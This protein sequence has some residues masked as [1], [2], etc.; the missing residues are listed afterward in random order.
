VRFSDV[1]SL[2]GAL[3][4]GALLITGSTSA[5]AAGNALQFDG[6]NDY[7]TFGADTVNLGLTKFTVELWFY[8]TGTGVTTST[9]T[10]GVTAVPLFT[11]GR[12]EADGNNR[13][14]NY[15]LGIRGTDNV[16]CADYEEGT[17][18]TSPGLNHPVAGVTAIRNNTWYHA[19]ATFDGTT[20]RLYLN[21]VLETELVVGASRL[22]QDQ[23]IQHAGL[24][25]AMTSTGVAAGYFLGVLDEA[26]IWG[27]ALTQ[28]E[29]VSNMGLELASGTGLNGRWGLNDGTGTTADNSIAASPDGTLTN[30]PVWVDGCPFAA[31]N[32]LKLGASNAYATFGNP[33]A[34]G[35]AQFT[36]ETWF[37][38][39]G[40]GTAVSTGTGGITALPLVTHG[41]A[42]AEGGNLDMNWFLGIRSSD[43][44]ICADFEEATTGATPGLNHPIAG[45]TPIATGQW[46][47]AAAT[48]DGTSWRLYLNGLLENELSVGQPPES[49]TLQHA[50]LGTFIRSD[51][52][53]TGFFNGTLDEV[54]VWSYARTMQQVDSTIND[55]ISGTRPGLAARWGLDEGAG[56]I[57][58]SSAGATLPGRIKGT[59][60]S[61]DYAAPFN[62]VIPTP[63]AAPTDLVAA[64]VSYAQIDL[65]WTDASDN[66]LSFEI[67]RSTD[68]SGGPFDPLVTLPAGTTSYE[69]HYLSP[70]D[71]Y[72]Y[73]V[74]AANAAGE[75]DWCAVACETTP[76]ENALAL[77]FGGST[78]HVAFGRPAALDL[79]EFTI[80][81]WFRRDGAGTTANTGS[82]GVYAIP[83]VTKG[84]G[85][86]D[87]DRR[88][89][90]FFLGIRGTDSV[91]CADFED[92][93]DGL[94]HPV[95]GVTP[96]HT[97][98]WHHAAATYDGAAWRLYLDGMLESELVVNE[99]PQWQSWQHAGLAAAFDTA[100]AASGHFDGVLDEA[101]IWDYA[102]TREEIR[103]TIN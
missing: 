64:A 54:R 89:M 13:D 32:S 41:S 43:N 72:C 61:W 5:F 84:V 58:R 48:Y 6:S 33:P 34:L 22:P 35:L 8:R 56:T 9:G 96:V 1:R 51:S 25:T 95:L 78:A 79:Q 21:G 52:T 59:G 75:S 38:R 92:V 18:Q 45:V 103:S 65:V 101:R 2:A 40:A 7:V 10:G 100:G 42:Q 26:R 70:D 47:H 81:T 93:P 17:G 73:R 28:Q 20:W 83:L 37:R 86:E 19:A 50:G 91:L 98:T 57:F 16:L 31:S 39:D 4:F 63:P 102:R 55:R 68:G 99:T 77:G 87:G 62:A 80:E 74:R 14:M 67:E 60:S 82:G 88:D 69:D 23:S 49:N 30:G 44:V 76:V 53:T 12:G 46:Y 3:L 97:G 24:A 85:Q 66:E 29:I 71:E 36:I 90:N 27:R 11:K 15:F 94:N